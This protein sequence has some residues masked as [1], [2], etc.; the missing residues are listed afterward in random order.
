MEL[1]INTIMGLIP[2]RYPFLLV[3]RVVD[4]KAGESCVGIKNVTI[5]DNFFQ[6]H[7]P[8]KPI[9]PGVLMVEAMAQTAGVVALTSEQHNGKVALFMSTDNVKF[10]R[11]VSPGDQLHFHVELVSDR[12][13]SSKFRCIAKVDDKIVTEADVSFSYVDN[14]FLNE[15]IA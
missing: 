14:A 9:M 13:R 12:S 6:G 15:G 10:R 11:I 4:L 8:N 1:D 5:N 3:D 2:H 7:F